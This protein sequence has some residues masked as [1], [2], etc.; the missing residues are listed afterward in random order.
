MEDMSIEK[1][2]DDLRCSKQ[3]VYQIISKACFDGK[4]C[5]DK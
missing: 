2:A 1:I 3:K 5:M 4:K